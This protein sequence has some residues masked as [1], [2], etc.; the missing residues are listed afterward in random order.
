ME[1][2]LNNVA[3]I[4]WNTVAS[5]DER[6]SDTSN[7]IEVQYPFLMFSFHTAVSI[8]PILQNYLPR[9]YSVSYSSREIK[10]NCIISQE[11]LVTTFHVGDQMFLMFLKVLGNFLTKFGKN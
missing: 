2:S 6:I 11:S 9:F 8:L 10:D 7:S 5:V 3:G 4:V 1:L